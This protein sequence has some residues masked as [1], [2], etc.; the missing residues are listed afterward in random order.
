MNDKKIEEWIE[1]EKQSKDYLYD[2]KLVY[3]S[4]PD[5]L[6]HEHCELCWARFG[7][8][9]QELTSGYYE[10][11]SKSWICEE[12]YQRFKNVFRWE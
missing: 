1:W 6:D 4:Y 3:L 12:C 11:D 2:K 5:S 9:A 10:P 8:N 7:N